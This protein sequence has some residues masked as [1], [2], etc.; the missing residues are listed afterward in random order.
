MKCV[1]TVAIEGINA[2]AR[3]ED[4][5]HGLVYICERAHVE[6]TFDEVDYGDRWLTYERILTLL[7]NFL[8]SAT[9]SD[10]ILYQSQFEI[11][12]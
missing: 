4:L 6:I 2:N 1:Y 7:E 12:E 9:I 11:W 5:Y 3:F 10:F 8:E